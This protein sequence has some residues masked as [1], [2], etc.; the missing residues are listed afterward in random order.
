MNL[1]FLDTSGIQSAS[2][3]TLTGVA[4]ATAPIIAVKPQWAFTPFSL[5][6]VLMAIGALVGLGQA[7]ASSEPVTLRQTIGRTLVSTAVAMVSTCIYYLKPAVDPLVVVGV[8]SLLSVLG[9]GVLS[10]VVKARFGVPPKQ[11]PE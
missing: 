5:L 7:L 8:G 10:E 2:V 9:S 4:A 1:N 6:L 3:A 11:P